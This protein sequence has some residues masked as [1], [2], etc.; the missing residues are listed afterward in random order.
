MDHVTDFGFN[1]RF[2]E[3]MHCVVRRLSDANDERPGA[4][5]RVQSRI[6]A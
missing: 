4:A 2:E 3:I 6:S 1:S 5:K